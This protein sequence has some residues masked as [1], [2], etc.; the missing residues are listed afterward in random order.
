MAIF[1]G[2]LSTICCF[3]QT[4]DIRSGTLSRRVQTKGSTKNLTSP[5]IIVL[6]LN[7]LGVAADIEDIHA[8][9]DFG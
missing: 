3:G 8:T 2:R 7:S 5:R 6:S 4:Y 1:A 9:C